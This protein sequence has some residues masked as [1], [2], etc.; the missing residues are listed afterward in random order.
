[1]GAVTRAFLARVAGQPAAEG[2]RVLLLI[3]DN[4]PRPVSREVRTWIG[5]HDRRVEAAGRGCRL[6]AC[7]LPGEGPR[8]D[9]IEPRRAHGKRAV[10]EPDRELAGQELRQR[11]RDHHRC[12]PVVEPLAR[13]LP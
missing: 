2:A 8:L 5:E 12:P 1:M 6:L 9:P 11:L 3:R 10:V 13:Q 4:A 7:R